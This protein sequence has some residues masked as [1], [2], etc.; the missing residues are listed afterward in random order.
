M[1]VSKRR[2]SH[3]VQGMRAANKALKVEGLT[4][5]DNCDFLKKNHYLCNNCNTYNKRSYGK[6]VILS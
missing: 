5:C 4:K 6:K 3:S 1:A 2:T